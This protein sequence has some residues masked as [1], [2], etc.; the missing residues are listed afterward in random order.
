MTGFLVY[1]PSAGEQLRTELARL[2]SRAYTSQRHQDAYPPD[3]RD[4]WRGAIA[5]LA[6]DASATMPTEWLE[7][8]PTMRNLAL[9]PE[10]RTQSAHFID[11]REGRVVGHVSLWDMTMAFGERQPI[12]AGY[13]EDVA[14]L[15]DAGGSGIASALMEQA[16]S[17]AAAAGLPLLGLST[18]I[19]IFYERLGWQ[20]WSGRSAYQLRTGGV[21]ANDRTMLLSLSDEAVALLRTASGEPLTGSPRGP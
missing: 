1:A 12:A 11:R 5:R 9:P 20:Q 2:L 18:G 7:R 21:E 6:A 15:P 16:R 10:E 19:P 14:T 8:F 17:H 4:R 3:E 13:V